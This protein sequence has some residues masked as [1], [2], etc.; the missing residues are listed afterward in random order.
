MPIS[1]SRSTHDQNVLVRRMSRETITFAYLG[2]LV[3]T[4]GWSVDTPLLPL[5]L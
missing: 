1:C 5:W 3:G 4:S 2:R